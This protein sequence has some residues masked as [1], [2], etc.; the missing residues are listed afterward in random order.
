VGLSP[1]IAGVWRC[2]AKSLLLRAIGE[3]R[4]PNCRF[5]VQ[6]AAEFRESLLSL[7]PASVSESVSPSESKTK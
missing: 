6:I 7:L 3:I 2:K 5:Q 1:H 4:G